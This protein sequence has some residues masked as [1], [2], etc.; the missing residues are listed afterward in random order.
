MITNTR[1]TIS[2]R[3]GGYFDNATVRTKSKRQSNGILKEDKYSDG[4]EVF[5]KS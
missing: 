4:I 3:V 2:L 5:R 1:S